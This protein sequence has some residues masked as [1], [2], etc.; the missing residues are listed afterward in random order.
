LIEALLLTLQSHGGGGEA[1]GLS[2]S[3]ALIAALTMEGLLFAAFS[4]GYNLTMPT[5]EGRSK[6]YAQGGFGWCIV[7]VIG[8][9]AVAAGAS[10]WELFGSGWPRNWGEF[11]LGVGLAAG[12]ATQPIFAG[13]INH[14]SKKE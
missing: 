9:V 14:Q 1:A 4:V 2:P 10:W 11:L 5:R 3:E 6:F 8:L 7:V 13:V 12:I